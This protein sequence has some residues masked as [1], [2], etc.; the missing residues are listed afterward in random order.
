MSKS[1]NQLVRLA[2]AVHL[3]ASALDSVT[4]GVDPVSGAPPQ[5]AE[6][7]AETMAYGA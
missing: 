2:G 1:P 6:I 3:F 4:R 5:L 7:S